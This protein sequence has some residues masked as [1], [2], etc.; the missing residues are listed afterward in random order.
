VGRL[1]TERAAHR[2]HRERHHFDPGDSASMVT[3]RRDGSHR[4][5]VTHFHDGITNA[6]LGSYSPDGRWLVY[7]LEKDGPFGLYRVHSDGSGR[8]S[9][10]LLSTFRP[11]FIDWGPKVND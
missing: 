11:A 9:I 5:R 10:L 2:R 6:Y 8:R 4:V 3:M 1:G 7:R